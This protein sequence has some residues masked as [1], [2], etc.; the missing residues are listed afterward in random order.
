MSLGYEIYDGMM[1]VSPVGRG[2]LG[3]HALYQRV[4]TDGDWPGWH[5]A[6]WVEQCRASSFQWYYSG[7]RVQSTMFTIRGCRL[8]HTAW[9]IFI[10]ASQA[11]QGTRLAIKGYLLPDF[12][13]WA[14]LGRMGGAMLDIML[15]L[16]FTEV[17]YSLKHCI[18]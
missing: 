14:V 15:P 18:H 6:K 7:S 17:L 11:E 12:P 10:W 2:D 3:H 13:G 4:S 16:V 9:W 8:P 5:L 1:T